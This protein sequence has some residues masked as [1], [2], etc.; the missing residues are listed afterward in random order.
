MVFELRSLQGKA[1]YT[2]PPFHICNGE[3]VSGNEKPGKKNN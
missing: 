1:V 3:E 2:Q